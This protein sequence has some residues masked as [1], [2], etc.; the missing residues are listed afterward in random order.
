MPGSARWRRGTLTSG[1]FLVVDA[2]RRRGLGCGDQTHT[3]TGAAACGQPGLTAG[4]KTDT[5][6]GEGDFGLFTGLNLDVQSGPSGENP[7]GSLAVTVDLFGTRFESDSITCLAVNGTA[8]TIGG[9]L[10]P[11]SVGYTAFVASVTDNGG[12][13]PDGYS[14][15]PATSAPT[16]CP[17]PAPFSIFGATGDI[18]VLDAGLRRGL[19]CGD[20]NHPHRDAADCKP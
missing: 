12:L 17:P 14:A 10:K 11:N 13:A 5:V 1:D 7:T 6:T 15:S 19:G 8:A 4:L 18:V 16:I 2:G 3:H 9:T 20:P